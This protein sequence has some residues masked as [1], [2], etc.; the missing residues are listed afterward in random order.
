MKSRRARS[1]LRLLLPVGIAVMLVAGG[2]R[3]QPAPPPPPPPPELVP[4]PAFPAPVGIE[5]DPTQEPQITVKSTASETVEEAR[6]NGQLV[7]IRVTP[8]NGRPYYLIPEP[9]SETFARRD[10]FDTG[11]R[12][13]MW[14][15]FSF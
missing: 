7:W 10:S 13:P 14:V 8:R 6:I 11:L 15:L 1:F 5:I 2:A 9:G 12:V 4:L 3:A